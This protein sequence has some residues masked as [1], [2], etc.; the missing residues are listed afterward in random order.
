MN[1]I[2]LQQ[3]KLYGCT[4]DGRKHG[5][6]YL[7]VVQ[8][9]IDAKTNRRFLLL[10]ARNLYAINPDRVHELIKMSFDDLDNTDFAEYGTNWAPMIRSFILDEDNA[11]QDEYGDSY[12][13]DFTETGV[14]VK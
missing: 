14:V 1:A 8:L 7:T 13:D 9:A 2:D 11:L 4:I 5:P 12:L 3:G 10:D 6:E